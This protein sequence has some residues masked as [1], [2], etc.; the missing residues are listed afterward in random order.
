MIVLQYHLFRIAR[1]Y[2][3][4]I[5]ISLPCFLW[6]KVEVGPGQGHKNGSDHL[7]FNMNK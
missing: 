7:H 6:P 3:L 2:T 4:H 1:L 5:F